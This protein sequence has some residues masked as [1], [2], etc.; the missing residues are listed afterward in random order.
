[1]SVKEIERWTQVLIDTAQSAPLDQRVPTCGDW[2]LGDLVWHLAEVQHFWTFIIEGRPD[3]A[4]QGYT[5]PLRPSDHE[6]P[7]FSAGVLSGLIGALTGARPEEPAWSWA[8]DYTVG[9]TLRRQEHEALVHAVDAVLATG[10]PIPPIEPATAVDG[11]NEV[12]DVMLTGEPDW[13][14]FTATGPTLE[15]RPTDSDVRWQLRFGRHRGIHPG[16]GAEVDLPSLETGDL[17]ES[18]IDE[19]VDATAA[20]LY[21][22]L[23]GRAPLAAG[24]VGQQLQALV[25]EVTA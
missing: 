14:T 18:V 25:A 9:F 24:P 6:L 10:Q 11:V 22:W 15:L 7:A 12:I 4:P 2:T 23:W 1:M 21:L 19:T 20:E 17:T 3:A 5:Q 13:G 16:S 8:N